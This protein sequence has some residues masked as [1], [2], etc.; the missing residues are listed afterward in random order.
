MTNQQPKSGLSLPAGT[1]PIVIILTLAILLATILLSGPGYRH[2]SEI[3]FV[4]PQTCMECHREQGESWA[5]TKMAKSFDALRPGVYAKEKESVG[6][7]PEADYTRVEGCLICHTTGYGLVGGFTSIEDTPELAGVTCEAC[8]GAG[9]M[10]VE[11]VMD[12]D[13][14]TFAAKDARDAGLIYPPTARVCRKC[15]NEDSPFIGIDY[16]F[17][18]SKRV[19][20]GTHA[21]Y[22]LKYDHED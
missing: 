19:A 3:G 15:H 13:D 20:S 10:Y 22:Q 16:Q 7:D 14:P 2:G 6:L 1:L 4:G 12:N 5:E 11:L 9:G 8:H 17:D 18:Y 21:H